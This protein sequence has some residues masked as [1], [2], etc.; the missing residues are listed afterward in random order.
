[1]SMVLSWAG[2]PAR[3]WVWISILALVLGCGLAGCRKPVTAVPPPVLSPPETVQE[4]IIDPPPPLEAPPLLLDDFQQAERL[5]QSGDYPGAAAAYRSFLDQHPDATRADQALFRL[6]LA[7]ALIKPSGPSAPLASAALRELIQRYPGS[8]LRPQAQL[9][10][11]LMSQVSELQTA[12]R[13]ADRQVRQLSDT[14]ERLKK[15]D[16]GLHPP[17]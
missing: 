9:I 2:V 3:G 17:P 14:L 7:H 16:L 13:N 11:D 4:E 1:M 15:I 6:G 5:F 8:A 12:K 10:L